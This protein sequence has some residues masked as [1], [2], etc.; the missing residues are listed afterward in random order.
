MWSVGAVGSDTVRSRAPGCEHG[1]GQFPCES[2][3][4]TWHDVSTGYLPLHCPL[5]TA[6][7]R[8][9]GFALATVGEGMR[10]FRL[11]VGASL[12]KPWGPVITANLEAQG[13]HVASRA[14]GWD[15]WTTD[16]G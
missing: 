16:N 12:Q 9:P 8:S 10:A 2:F 1:D 4:P 14:L 3:C 5:P 7:Q 11:P 15:H 13:K 6:T